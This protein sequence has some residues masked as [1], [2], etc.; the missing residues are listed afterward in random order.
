MTQRNRVWKEQHRNSFISSIYII[1][2]ISGVNSQ[3]KKTGKIFSN[4]D[5]FQS[6][7]FHVGD[8][9]WRQNV[10]VIILGCW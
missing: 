4:P 2:F 7:Y 6:G 5:F 10:M 3:K 9:N 1:L 8:G